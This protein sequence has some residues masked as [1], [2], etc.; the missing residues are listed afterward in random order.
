MYDAWQAVI[1]QTLFIE[2]TV[3]PQNGPL[4]RPKNNQ[5]IGLRY[6]TT[7]FDETIIPLACNLFCKRP[8]YYETMDLTRC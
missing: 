3:N 5:Y 4:N 7:R 2:G 6:D 8:I 1:I